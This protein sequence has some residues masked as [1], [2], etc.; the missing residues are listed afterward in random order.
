MSWGNLINNPRHVRTW[1]ARGVHTICAVVSEL[2]CGG[3]E[4]PEGPVDLVVGDVALGLAG[5][6]PRDVQLAHVQGLHLQVGR[7]RRHCKG[8][9]RVNGVIPHGSSII[10]G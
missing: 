4:V 10:M 9:N 7:A 1:S 3:V 6:V 5:R 2:V 8:G